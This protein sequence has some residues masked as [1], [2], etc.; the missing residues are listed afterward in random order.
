MI[1]YVQL[2]L[3]LKIE[4]QSRM[5]LSQTGFDARATGKKEEEYREKELELDALR[6]RIGKT[7]MG[8]LAPM[9]I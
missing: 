9:V 8:V 6:K 4:K 2:S 7:G 5:L 1:C 3:E